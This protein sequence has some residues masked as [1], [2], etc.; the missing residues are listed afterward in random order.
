MDPKTVLLVTPDHAQLSMT[1]TALRMSGL[2]VMRAERC[3]AA[4]ASLRSSL[5]AAV[6]V[7]Y[8]FEIEDGLE[9]LDSL[10]P[11]RAATGLKVVAITPHGLPLPDVV[12]IERQVDLLFLMPVSAVTIAERTAALLRAPPIAGK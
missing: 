3:R 11:A 12:R 7:E 9:L 6:V 1:A 5:P 10:Q 2:S 8:P 4:L